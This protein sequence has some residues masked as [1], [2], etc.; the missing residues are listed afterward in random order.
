M[1]EGMHVAVLRGA[2]WGRMC[3]AGRRMLCAGSSKTAR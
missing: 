3:C 1:E 2:A